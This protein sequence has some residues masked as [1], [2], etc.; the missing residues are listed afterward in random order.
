MRKEDTFKPDL[1]SLLQDWTARHALSPFQSETIRRTIVLPSEAPT[2]ELTFAWWN[3]LF[4]PL[5]TALKQSTDLMYPLRYV[6][7]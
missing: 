2:P 6:N 4:S 7:G 1:D 3:Q 5:A